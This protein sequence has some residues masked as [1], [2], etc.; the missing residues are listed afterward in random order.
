MNLH[1]QESGN[2][3]KKLNKFREIKDEPPDTQTHKYLWDLRLR[4]ES[5]LWCQ[6]QGYKTSWIWSPL[7]GFIHLVWWKSVGSFLWNCEPVWAHSSKFGPLQVTCLRSAAMDLSSLWWQ[8]CR[9]R[10]QLSPGQVKLSF[11]E[12]GFFILLPSAQWSFHFTCQEQ[13]GTL[14]QRGVS[15]GACPGLSQL[16]LNL[17][18]TRS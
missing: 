7:Y 14:S 4:L 2:Y 9:A 11:T 13:H 18:D 12:R 5:F 16:S 1:L 6:R 15:G 3:I 17:R 8:W 10:N